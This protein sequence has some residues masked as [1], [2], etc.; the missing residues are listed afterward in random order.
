MLSAKPQVVYLSDEQELTGLVR[1]ALSE[2]FDVTVVTEVT[3]LDDV[4]RTIRQIKPDY[5]IVDPQ[6]PSLD[7]DE[8]RHRMKV[9]AELSGIQILIVREDV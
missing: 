5:V 1:S 8:L 2:R 7:H 9:D 4:L 3:Q 6:V